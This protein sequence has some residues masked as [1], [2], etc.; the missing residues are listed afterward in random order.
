V[1]FTAAY[2][3]EGREQVTLRPGAKVLDLS[4]KDLHARTASKDDQAL[5]EAVKSQAALIERLTELVERLMALN[6]GGY[7]A[8]KTEDRL[9]ILNP[10]AV[11]ATPARTPWLSPKPSKRSP[12]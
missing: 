5:I 1:A 11:E 8:V 9:I 12:A 10:K 4:E 3:T 2:G 6:T 7:D